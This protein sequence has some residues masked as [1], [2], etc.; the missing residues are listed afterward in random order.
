LN[1]LGQNNKSYVIKWEVDG[2]AYLDL[3]T[4]WFKIENQDGTDL[5]NFRPAKGIISKELF[6]VLDLD[7]NLVIKVAKK[8]RWKSEEYLTDSQGNEI[9]IMKRKGVWKQSI[10]FLNMKKEEVLVARADSSNQ[11]GKIIDT[12]DKLI[13]EFSIA[14]EEI[15][16]KGFFK[17]SLFKITCTLKILDESF[18][19]KVLLCFFFYILIRLLPRP[20]GGGNGGE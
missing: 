3:S 20:S 17:K 16:K 12:Q 4:D 2:S 8:S 1:L 19:R 7:D 5:G 10:F 9:G 6:S 18:D 15:K 14:I 11:T 13:A